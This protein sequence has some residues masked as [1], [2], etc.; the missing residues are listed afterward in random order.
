L[1]VERSA[2]SVERSSPRGAVFLSY[3]SQDA[4]AARRICE[5]LGAAGIEVWFDQSE[6]RGG[7][8]WDQKIRKQIRDCALFVP[9]VSANTQARR[10]GYFRLEWKLADDRTHLMARGTPFLL[11]VCID[12][13]RDWDA[14]VPDSFSVVQ[15]VRLPGGETPPAFCERV[16]SLLGGASTVSVVGGALR[17]DE[18][19]RSK[20]SRHKAPPTIRRRKLWLVAGTLA[21]AIVLLG[22]WRPWVG[23]VPARTTSPAGPLSEARQL[24]LKAR[25]LI[26]DD[27]LA[28][29][30]NFRL[31]EE[32][33]ERA[34]KLDP[35]DGEAWATLARVSIETLARNYES[36]PQRREAARSQAERAIRLAPASVDAGLAM[37]AHSLQIREWADAERRFRQLLEIAPRDPRLAWGLGRAL[38][39]AGKISEASEVRLNHPAF[40][41]RDPRPLVDEVGRLR[42]EGRLPEADALLRRAQALAPTV[43]GYYHQLHSLV[44]D[45]GDFEAAR[46]VLPTIPP[47][48]QQEDMVAMAALMLWFRLG[49][50]EKALAVLQRQPREFFQEGGFE[51]SKGYLA[52]WAARLAGRE[53]AAQ[54][55]WS[56]ALAVIEQKLATDSNH[57]PSLWHRTILLALL[58]RIEEGEKSWKLV[59]DMPRQGNAN[60]PYHGALFYAVAGRNDEAVQWLERAHAEMP[61]WIKS[62]LGSDPW[63]APLRGDPRVQRM[64]AAWKAEI[65]AL[66]APGASNS[67]PQIPYSEPSRSGADAKSVAVLAFENMSS[68]RETEY[69]SDGMSEEILHALANDPALR[70]AA[71]TSSFSFKGR[72]VPAAEMG[73]ALNVARIVEGTVSKSG[74]RVRITI[75]LINA[76]DGYQMWSERFERDLTDIFALQAEIA[77][78]V[79]Q[80]IVGG[81]GTTVATAGDVVVPTKNLAAY[82]AYLRGSARQT[83]IERGSTGGGGEAEFAEAVHHD[84]NF[85]LAWARL[86]ETRITRRITG[87]NRSDANAARAKTAAETAVRLAPELPEAHLALGLI[88]LHADRDHEAAQRELTNA[89]RLRPNNAEVAMALAQLA[90]AR[91]E[92][93]DKLAQLVRQS[94]DL[95]PQNTL[96]LDL[97]TQILTDIGHFADSARLGERWR[98]I[99]RDRVSPVIRLARNY[100]AWTGDAQGVLDLLSLRSSPGITDEEKAASEVGVRVALMRGDVLAGM[101]RA[102][103]AIAAYLVARGKPITDE[104]AAGYSGPRG[105]RLLAAVRL[106]GFQAATVPQTLATRRAEGRAAVEAF[107]GDFPEVSLAAA[108]RAV[109]EAELGEKAAAR[110]SI[111]RA[112]R[113]AEETRDASVIALLRR[114]RAEVLVMLGENQAAITEL[115]AVHAMGF[116]HGYRL[117]MQPWWA[118]LRGDPQFQQLMKEAEARADAQP[119]P[120]R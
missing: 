88:R 10:E 24:T 9:V 12:E 104:D 83:G 49:D 75:Q 71:R 95:D 43:R 111:D 32:L 79:A 106:A 50:G 66:R 102:A 89:A 42:R 5:A 41:G 6:L 11:P 1:S 94:A 4:A 58:G 29:R 38:E 115:R 18:A 69:F 2:L 26:D 55:E 60:S 48:V 13:T 16:K 37:A 97:S 98:S 17:S 53:I 85:A 76:S 77:G 8:S 65:D 107:E 116:A 39:G 30:E 52:G 28:V 56:R 92:W 64:I 51:A 91:G 63:F 82:D 96:V 86:A 118:P 61:L 25:A 68:D 70:V 84:P 81:A 93:G 99:S 46:V 101:G 67:K 113:L 90:W 40:G 54:A 73:R 33:C 62:G 15:W 109:F 74:N 105:S 19:G 3:A 80:K 59:W 120:K 103:E 22:L 87:Q 20:Q 47:Q 78:K 27:L 7:D 34:T 31:A 57:V 36:T 14:L 72:K 44:A 110:Q 108:Y 23:S 119:R 117:R 100:E 21:G 35:T 112:T 114:I 45:W